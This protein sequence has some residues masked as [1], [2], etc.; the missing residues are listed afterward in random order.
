[1]AVK[2]RVEDPLGFEWSRR[3][4]VEIRAT[5]VSWTRLSGNTNLIVHQLLE[6]KATRYP[7]LITLF[8]RANGLVI[9]SLRSRGAKPWPG[10]AAA[11]WRAPNACGATLP[12]SVRSIPD[13]ILY[14]QRVLNPRAAERANPWSGRLICR[15]GP[16]R[17]LSGLRSVSWSHSEFPRLGHL[18][19]PGLSSAGAGHI[20][21][22]QNGLTDPS[23]IKRLKK[24]ALQHGPVTMFSTLSCDPV[25]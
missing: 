6:Q 24:V 8:R 16:E 18:R 25:S 2:R 10:R 5:V 20:S 1:M 3:N 4:V 21:R 13:A 23:G 17:R 9:A 15:L 11:G 22:E 14:L 12:R 19:K 7:V